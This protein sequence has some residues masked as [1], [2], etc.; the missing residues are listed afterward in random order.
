MTCERDWALLN[1]WRSWPAAHQ[2]DWPDRDALRE[3]IAE[4][5]TYPPLVFAGSCD[6]LRERM[7][8]V[9]RG[10]AFLL[11]AGDCAET[12]EALST[13]NVFNKVKTITQMAAIFAGSSSVPVVKVGRIAGQ[14]A[15]PRSSPTE[16]RAGRTLPA[17]RGDCVNSTEFSMQGRT[18]DPRRLK[19]MYHASAATLELL[20]AC[21]PGRNSDPRQVAA[22]NE[23]FVRSSVARRHYQSLFRHIDRGLHFASARDA[24]RANS[25]PTEFYSSHEALL[26]DYESAF[27]RIDPRSGN[28]YDV[29]GH[30]LWIGDRTR[31]LDGAHI[32]FASRI[33]NP[34]GVKLGPTAT[35]EEALALIERLD[36][37]NEPGRLT[38]ITRMGAGAVRERLPTIVDKVTAAGA[39]V[40]W[41]CDPMHGNSFESPS[42]HKTRCLDDILDEAKGFFEVHHSLGTHPGGIHLELTGEDVTECLGGTDEV[43]MSDLHRRYETACDPRLN[44]N[45]ALDLAFRIAEF[46]LARRSH[47]SFGSNAGGKLYSIERL[48]GVHRVRP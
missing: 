8:A 6:R 13:E 42:G 14:Y 34:I 4:L 31:Q 11:Q 30:M 5:E 19:W 17:Y 24:T 39:T 28:L 15:K 7:S 45:Q 43:R 16:T 44:R 27:T 2:P 22:W 3:V 48:R 9:A 18:P 46:R 32:E 25:E 35:P 26:L 29:S 12:F 33:R 37:D 36:P 38:F 21:T 20:R 40:A 10:E 41:V 1:S 47:P 23:E